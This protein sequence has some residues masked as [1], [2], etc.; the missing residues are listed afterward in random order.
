[1]KLQLSIALSIFLLPQLPVNCVADTATD[2]LREQVAGNPASAPDAVVAAIKAA[3]PQAP[4]LAGPIAAA[5][6]QGLGRDP[7]PGQIFAIVYA[8]VRAIPNSALRI[9]RAAVKVAPSAA[10]QIAAAAAKAVPNPWKQVRYQDA[11][12]LVPVRAIPIC[13]GAASEQSGT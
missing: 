9:V 11:L 4:L 7:K 5:A 8:A 3:G 10:P 2:V 12:H 13:G 6:I 1:M